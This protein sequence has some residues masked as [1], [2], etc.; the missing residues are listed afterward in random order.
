[1]FTVFKKLLWFFRE[2]RKRYTLAMT[3]LFLLN[4]V[5]IAPPIIIG[6]AIDAMNQATLTHT[7]LLLTITFYLAIVLINYIF[8]FIW[9]YQLFGGANL[10]QQTLRIRLMQHFLKMT[11]PFFEKNRTGDLMARATNDL[12]A[13]S[14]TAG[15][16]ILTLID[17]TT[18]S[19]TIFI[20]MGVVISWKL[21]LVSLL[22]MPIVA[23][24]MTKYG[25]IVHERF[26]LAQDAFGEMNDRVL[27]TIAGIRVVRAFV[28]EQAEQ[29]RFAETAEMVHQK[30]V[31][32]ARIDSLFEP[33][34]S[35]LVG[36][37]YLIGLGYG[38]YMVF[39]SEITLGEL[40]SFNVYLGMLIWP[41]LAV[42]E[43]INTL[44]R[45]NASLD[46]VNETLAYQPDVSD[47][48]E[49]RN[50]QVMI[51][52]NIDFEHF[53]FR[54]PLSMENNLQDI[55]LDIKRGQTIGIVGKTGSGKSTIINQL[56]REYPPAQRGVLRING[57]PIEQ[58]PLTQLHSWLGYVPQEPMLFSRSVEENV[59]FGAPEASDEEVHGALAIAG[60]IK[61]IAALP[62]GIQTLV[63]EKGVSL[64]GG[65]KQR[66]ALARAL[67]MN[68]EILL[69]DDAMSAVDARTEAHILGAIRR[70][71]VGKTTLIVTHRLSAVEHADW[72]IALN[73][74]KIME[75][76][77]H[78]DLIQRGGWYRDQYVRQQTEQLVEQG[79]DGLEDQPISTKMENGVIV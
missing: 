25:K 31:A 69:L 53:T 29:E 8:G 45:G 61:D 41:M 23:F 16:G 7:D 21:T 54:Y 42:G 6:K 37:T 3:I 55:S 77:K 67:V 70:E 11:P 26:L 22:P 56:L 39:Q 43:L 76:G 28:Q 38:S 18:F 49:T 24:A 75:E 52:Q 73:D 9:M 27:E 57:I 32:V 79:I 17:S 71:R 44:Q 63:G 35:L 47:T 4:F 78:T 13:V 1:M 46:R 65:Q 74:G 62:L 15:F 48:D 72:I 58:I 51:P 34:I 19:A 68:P 66:I 10:L 59:R 40:T 2:H 5:E 14:Q 36:L 33:T 64:S 50:K 60:F 20:T 30:N 12:N